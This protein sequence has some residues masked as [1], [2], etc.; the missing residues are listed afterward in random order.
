MQLDLRLDRHVN[1]GEMVRNVVQALAKERQ[2][3]TEQAVVGSDGNLSLRLCALLKIDKVAD[4]RL[5]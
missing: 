3:D 2:R 5:R 1:S 4:A